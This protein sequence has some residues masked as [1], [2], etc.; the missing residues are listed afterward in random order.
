[1]L[2]TES[3]LSQFSAD[4][5]KAMTAEDGKDVGEEEEETLPK[6]EEEEDDDDDKSPEMSENLKNR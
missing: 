1:M 6:E 5:S 4:V 2:S 3:A